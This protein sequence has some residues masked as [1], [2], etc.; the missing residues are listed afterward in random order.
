[1]PEQPGEAHEIVFSFF[2]FQFQ[3]QFI[4]FK[5]VVQVHKIYRRGSQSERTV[6]GPTVNYTGIEGN[7]TA[8]ERNY[9]QNQYILDKAFTFRSVEHEKAQI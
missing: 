4:A 2:F 7:N 1:M 8:S 9:W 5:K 6:V 3:F